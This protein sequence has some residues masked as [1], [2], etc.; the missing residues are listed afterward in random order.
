MKSFFG[1]TTAKD[2][3]GKKT[4]GIETLGGE[5]G[6][7]RNGRLSM[8]R[9]Y[10]L[11]R[12][13]SVDD[14]F[15]QDGRMQHIKADIGKDFTNII[16]SGDPGK[17]GKMYA[18]IARKLNEY[19]VPDIDLKDDRA[20]A[21][22]FYKQYALFGCMID[23][24]QSI[25]IKNPLDKLPPSPGK[26]CLE[27]FHANMN[28]KDGDLEKS[29]KALDG[30]N[31]LKNSLDDRYNFILGSD[32]STVN[33]DKRKDYVGF[34]RYDSPKNNRFD[35]SWRS[36]T[37]AGNQMINDIAP[38]IQNARGKT[39]DETGIDFSEQIA[40][41]QDY[42]MEVA[43][44]MPPPEQQKLYDSY[45]KL[46]EKKAPVND[47]PV[48]EDMGKE[49]FNELKKEN[50]MPEIGKNQVSEINSGELSTSLEDK[51]K[52]PFKK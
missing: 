13:Y 6:S 24:E 44:D 46:P 5:I 31:T 33:N 11:S 20:L 18:D 52:D 40:K 10:M 30:M 50:N 27:A 39:F 37:H 42:V 36:N 22:D 14:I 49:G 45:L 29:R 25:G 32:Y 34:T 21:G 1:N 12:G 3:T 51:A 38:K 7:T 28:L 26:E 9:L 2:F 23:F 17:I 47:A 4:H 19:P 8:V 16:T 48:R 41:R 35:D 15:S 43:I